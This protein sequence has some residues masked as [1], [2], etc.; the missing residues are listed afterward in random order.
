MT[1][2]WKLD[3]TQREN[4][5]AALPPR[6]ER[7]IADHVTLSV[8]GKIPPEAVHRAEIVGYVDD[9]EGVE[10]YIVSIDG[11]TGRPDGGTWHI[12]W[13]L[14]EHRTAKESNSAIAALGWTEVSPV[15]LQL[16]PAL[17]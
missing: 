13:S 4:L 7:A 1:L 5:L 3:R 14:A 6:Y 8:A 2:G 17:W 16:T 9:G 15:P 11:T 10:A 12:T